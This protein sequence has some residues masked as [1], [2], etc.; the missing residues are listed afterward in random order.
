MPPRFQ[1]LADMVKEIPSELRPHT[2]QEWEAVL[3]QTL[4]EMQKATPQAAAF[5]GHALDMLEKHDR[6]A[7]TEPEQEYDYFGELEEH[8]SGTITL[9]KRSEGKLTSFERDILDV[10]QDS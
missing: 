2:E 4:E 9:P 6:N 5:A 7:Q 1:Q 8:P 10:F 3:D